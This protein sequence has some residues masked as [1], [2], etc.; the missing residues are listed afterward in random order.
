MENFKIDFLT[1]TVLVSKS[2]V[3]CIGKGAHKR[4]PRHP[5][6]NLWNLSP[7]NHVIN[8]DVA[9]ATRTLWKRYIASHETNLAFD[10]TAYLCNSFLASTFCIVTTEDNCLDSCNKGNFKSRG[11]EGK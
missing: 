8:A 10:L 1:G 5:K 2:R 7:A 6:N 3:F 4:P 11:Q 9:S